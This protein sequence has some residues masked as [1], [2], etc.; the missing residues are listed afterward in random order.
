MGH[1]VLKSSTIVLLYCLFVFAGVTW[2][3]DPCFDVGDELSHATSDSDHD[4]DP[5][6]NSEPSDDSVPLLQCL[7]YLS[8]VHLADKSYA[9]NNLRLN[10]LFKRNTLFRFHCDLPYRL[11]LSI[12]QI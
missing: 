12:L 11:F 10:A 8:D 1:H 7:P 5:S 4:A 6:S 9:T 2:A 3:F